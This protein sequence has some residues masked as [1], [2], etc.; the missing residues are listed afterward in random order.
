[1]ALSETAEGASLDEMDLKIIK[2]LVEDAKMPFAELGKQVHLTAPA[3]H[4]RV[5]K[6]EKMGVIR[7]YIFLSF[8]EVKT[9]T[10]R[11]GH[12]LTLLCEQGSIWVTSSTEAKDFVVA[13]GEQ[14][15]M[16]GELVIQG[17]S[18]ESEFEVSECA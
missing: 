13:A 7:N 10:S 4:A 12:T 11:K 5:K 18:R 6:M 15:E 2:L 14:L 1:M 3:V 9:L 8:D 17:L 16:S